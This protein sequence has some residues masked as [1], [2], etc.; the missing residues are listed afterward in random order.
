[1]G[2]LN[3]TSVGVSGNRMKTFGLYV[4]CVIL[5][6]IFS[7]VMIDIALKTSYDIID[8]Y[9]TVPNGITIDINEAKATYVNGYVGGKITNQNQ[10]ALNTYIKIDLY[11]KRDVCLGTKYVAIKDLKQNETQDF[12]MGFK[13]TDVDYAKISLVNEV[14][15][16]EPEESFIS[17]NLRGIF[18]LKTVLFLCMFG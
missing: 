5:F 13:F 12:R 10:T 11:T 17:N 8:T 14:P 16:N 4:L 6:F 9:K 2:K 15:E 3:I 18:L 7:N 1:M